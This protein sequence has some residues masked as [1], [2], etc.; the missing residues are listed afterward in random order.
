[1][2]YDNFVILI[3][4]L[5]P[6]ERLVELIRGL[7][8][9]GFYRIFVTDDGSSDENRRYFEE[10]QWLGAKVIRHEKTLGKGVSLRSALEGADKAFGDTDF[11]ITAEPDGSYSPDDIEKVALEL[12]KNP[13]HFVLGARKFERK[14]GEKVTYWINYCQRKFFRVTNHG[15]DCPDP[16]SGLRGFPKALKKL[17]LCTEGKSYDYELN[18]LDA[19]TRK[20][21]TSVVPVSSEPDFVSRDGNFRPVVDLLGMYLKFWRYLF[22]SNVATIF[23]LVFFAVFKPLLS[24]LGAMDIF[25]ATVCARIISG[26]VGYVLNRRISFRSHLNVG[27]EMVR[28]FIVF[29]AQMAASGILVTVLRIIPVPTVAVKAVVDFCLFFAVYNIQKSWVFTSEN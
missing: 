27:P 26:L 11:Y 7:C 24:V 8:D 17:A 12:L 10:A 9:R 14:E 13:K 19:V 1:M 16:R 18:F 22:T 2:K 20:A 23:D 15:R 5:N 28:Y 21:Q 25:A 6:D 4:A 3:P 29:V